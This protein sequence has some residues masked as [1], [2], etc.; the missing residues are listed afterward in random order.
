MIRK[1]AINNTIIYTLIGSSLLPSMAFAGQMSFSQIPPGLV[2]IPPA[3][4]VI[5]TVDDSGS[6]AEGVVNTGAAISIRNPEKMAQLRIALDEVFSDETLLPN[7]KIRLAWQSM[8]NNGRSPGAGALAAGAVNS[9]KTLDATHRVNF[10]A[11]AK[12]L[13]PSN[14]TPSHKMLKQAYD[15]M[16]VGKS[17]N[18]PWSFNPGVKETP[19]LGCRRAY[20]IFLT[21]GGW[22]GQDASVR[23]GNVDNARLTFPDGVV[24][25]P[26]SEQTRVYKGSVDNLLADW[27]LKMWSEDLQPNIA[28]DVK[29][30]T[31][32]GVPAIETVGGVRLQRYWN[33][34]HNPAT[35]Q[36]LSQYTIGYGADAYTWPNAPKWSFADDDN[37]GGDYLNLVKGTTTWVPNV[38]GNLN[39]NNPAELWH[40]A[41][42]S[43]GKYYPTGPGRKYDLKEAFRNILENINLQNSADVGSMAASST[44]NIRTDLSRFVA[45]YDPKKWS[46]Y[47]YSNRVN[48]S[49]IET[50]DTGWGL[51]ADQPPPKNRIT[52]AQKL[53]A[54]SNVSNRVILT[55]NDRTNAGV[56][57]EWESDTSKLS[58]NQKTV[59]NADSLGRD[60][61]NF[62]RGDRT[63]EGS[64]FRVRDSRQ[65][66]IV[67][68]SVWYVASPSANYSNVGY[69]AFTSAQKNRLPMIYVGGNDGMLHGFSAIDGDEEIAYVPKGVYPSL[70]RL[71]DPAY[72]HSYYVDGS[73]FTGDV[74]SNPAATIPSD[75]W[76]T[77]LVGSLAAGG[78]GYYVLDVTKPGYKDGTT[79]T[80]FTKS[81]AANLVVLDR[82]IHSTTAIDAGSDDEDIGH[83]FA[84][85]VIDDSNPY[86]TTQ[87]TQLN[88]GG[89]AVI[90]GNG[91]NSKNERPV[92]LVQYLDGAK[93]LRKIVATGSQA[94]SNPV[95]P[96]KDA[97]I[98]SNGLSSPRVVDID[99]DG[100]ADVVYAGDLKGNLWK[101]DLTSKNPADWGVAKF[102]GSAK[103]LFVATY[104]NDTA[105]PISIAPIVRAN[106]RGAGGMMVAFGTGVNLTD[107]DRNSTAVQSA[108]SVHDNTIYRKLSGG[109]IEINT[110]SATG[111]L[112][113]KQVNGRTR[114]VQQ[115]LVNSSSIAGSGVSTGREFWAIT[116]K[117]VNYD[118]SKAGDTV[119]QGWYF[120]FQVTSERVLTPMSFF[121]ASNNL[122]VESVTPAYGG[123][124]SNEESCEPSGT[125]EKRYV[126][127]FN[128]MDGN[129][130]SVQVMDTNG[131][132]IYSKTA[133]GGASRM[134][135]SSGASSPRMEPDVMVRTGADGKQDRYARMPEQP[136]RP[137]WRQLK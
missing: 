35:W 69:A 58:A 132:G 136:L 110:S 105:Q 129:A 20:H 118:P 28:N 106:D 64:P 75:R 98:V 26:S 8:W 78:K 56:L 90:L 11:F 15:Y 67:N 47:V 102:D 5:L 70:P 92:L 19:Y 25:D 112:E 76:R 135:V 14:G 97:N 131:D 66:D 133:D 27:A 123:N 23:P 74:Y 1:S 72:T 41:I 36:H 93:N 137:S 54:L 127:L 91:Y 46:G 3:P 55:V 82:T 115:E 89:W 52:T 60:R 101:F 83:I 40:M 109:G 65:G 79:G 104:V 10:R 128:I 22:N 13:T 7:G 94:R 86:T 134:S 107:A 103:P 24:Y 100:K 61:L 119:K 21:D 68:S 37:Y 43:R 122:L 99:G 45:G 62:L 12:N 96:K 16:K 29:P 53:D 57:F 88:D 130:P 116:Q 124:G 126:T 117:P 42:N 120:D 113:P 87:I 6:M 4:N 59:L 48:P 17:L 44:T 81:N 125:P 33:P 108:Y 73:P 114:L 30:S 111:G 31:I 71:S 34:K 77:M 18:S 121:D 9:M 85:P 63:R 84:P 38:F 80:D 49:G 2:S 51:N 39:A 32:D 95:D 50:A